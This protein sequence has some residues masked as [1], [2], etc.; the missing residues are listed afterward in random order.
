MLFFWQF[1]PARKVKEKAVKLRKS[2]SEDIFP[3]TTSKNIL[4]M[5]F[6]QVVLEQIWNFDLIVFQPGE[7]RKMEDLENPRE[8]WYLL[9]L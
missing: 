5:T 4:T 1:L 6:R 3:N 2:L 9:F 7:E 8:V